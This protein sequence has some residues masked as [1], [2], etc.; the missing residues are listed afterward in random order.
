MVWTVCWVA[1]GTFFFSVPAKAAAAPKSISLDG[2]E[3]FFDVPPV[4]GGGAVLV[5]VVAL[6]LGGSSVKMAVLQWD[7][8]TLA[9]KEAEIAYMHHMPFL[10]YPMALLYHASSFPLS[11]YS[12]LMVLTPSWY[13]P[14]HG[15]HPLM[16]LTLS[17]YSPPHGTHPLMVL[18]PSWYSPPHG[19]YPIVSL[20]SSVDNRSLY[21]AV[22]TFS[23]LV[24]VAG[25]SSSEID[26]ACVALPRLPRGSG[27]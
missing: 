18:T 14:P 13:S 25:G 17:W 9:W 20:S 16:V 2:C 10:V 12:P 21:G 27:S 23:S 15:T 5:M 1:T 7:K 22:F 4:A 19:T 11:W 26:E 3:D 6:G 8:G 24:C